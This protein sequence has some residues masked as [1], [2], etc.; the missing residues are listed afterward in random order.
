MSELFRHV[1]LVRLKV[2]DAMP[3]TAQV[4]VAAGPN[5]HINWIDCGIS[6]TNKSDDSGWS[7]PNVQLAEMVYMNLST[8]LKSSSTVFSACNAYL[9]N[10]TSVAEAKVRVSGKSHT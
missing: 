5:G 7:P 3:Q 10:F 6:S 1:D 4:N 9:A 8:A 2:S